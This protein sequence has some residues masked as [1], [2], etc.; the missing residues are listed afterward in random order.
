MKKLIIFI[1]FYCLLWTTSAW[2]IEIYLKN[3]DKTAGYI[4]E[5]NGTSI[6]V[7]TIAEGEVRIDKSFIDLKKT[8]P[9]QHGPCQVRKV[10]VIPPAV[11]W[12]KDMAVG[13]T[14]S[15][16]DTQKKL[17]NFD[18]MID[19]KSPINEESMKLD[20]LY[21]S[22]DGKM[23]GRKF[24]GNLRYASNFGSNL[25]WHTYYGMEG[26][27]DYFE[28]IYYRLNPTAGAGYWF[29]NTNNLKIDTELGLGYQYTDYR[30]D[31]SPNGG[32]P[33]LVPRFCLD[34]RIIGTLHLTEEWE[35][36]PS[37]EYS[38]DFRI[39]SETD[40]INQIN[41][42]WSYKISYVNDFNSVPAVGFKKD[43]YT[44]VTSLVYH[45]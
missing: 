34:K 4:M 35:D 41:P 18:T 5:D 31:T 21:S 14:Q 37:V 17:W 23:D 36:Y 10:T 43:D 27:Q 6:L 1:L 7:Q 28:D 8:Y 13:Y 19:R 11:V 22:T 45:Y 38:A 26:N 40:L 30:L 16:G 9:K 39:R 33:V 32:D 42:Q 29:S 3:G 20:S 24:Y 44:W 2:A 25:K 12:K 15:G